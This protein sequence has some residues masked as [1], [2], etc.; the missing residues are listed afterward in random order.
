M[1]PSK[2]NKKAPCGALGVGGSWPTGLPRANS[3]QYAAVLA[4]LLL[5][6]LLHLLRGEVVV[7][8]DRD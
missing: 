4:V 7:T 1:L 2:G 8:L 5:P 6:H 3:E